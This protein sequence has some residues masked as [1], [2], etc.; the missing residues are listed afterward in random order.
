MFDVSNL[1]LEIQ[2]NVEE[3]EEIKKKKKLKKWLQI[4]S[5]FQFFQLK[6]FIERTLT[7]FMGFKAETEAEV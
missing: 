7:S 5:F 6:N 1:S 2:K 4:F 3:S